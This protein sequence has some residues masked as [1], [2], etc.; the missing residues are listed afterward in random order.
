M[1]A[2]CV[3]TYYQPKWCLIF[4][5]RL[6]NCTHLNLIEV[7]SSFKWKNVICGNS[8]D[9]LVCRVFCSIKCQSCLT[10]NQ[11]QQHNIQH[12]FYHCAN[13]NSISLVYWVPTS[14]GPVWEWSLVSHVLWTGE[15]QWGQQIKIKWTKT[16]HCSHE[17]FGL[18]QKHTHIVVWSLIVHW[19]YWKPQLAV[20]EKLDTTTTMHTQRI[21][22]LMVYVL[23]AGHTK[24]SSAYSVKILQQ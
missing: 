3:K 7:L 10:W 20:A 15:M 21:H 8:N 1:A 23:V 17:H 24:V 4:E 16:A 6:V 18:M 2:T 12:L 22:S 5:N 9:W 13:R 14:T 19:A 11:L